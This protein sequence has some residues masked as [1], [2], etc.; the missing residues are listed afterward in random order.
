MEDTSPAG[1]CVNEEDNC[2]PPTGVEDVE[3]GRW[4]IFI[5]WGKIANLI[6]ENK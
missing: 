2:A 4:F 1:K 3:R 6:P 5:I